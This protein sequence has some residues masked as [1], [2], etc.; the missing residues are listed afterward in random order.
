[1][2]LSEKRRRVVLRLL[3]LVGVITL[4]AALLPASVLAEQSCVSKYTVQSGDTLAR[5]ARSNGYTTQELASA[6]SLSLPYSVQPGDEL[7]RPNSSKATPT[8]EGEKVSKSNKTPKFSAFMTAK[9]LVATAAEFPAKQSY[10]V[11]LRGSSA[12]LGTLRGNKGD[13]LHLTVDLS[14][15]EFSGRSYSVC[16]K[17]MSTNQSYCVP[18]SVV[19][20]K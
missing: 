18:V 6:N 17:N 2:V 4:A 11:K 3:A 5:I 10:Q 20:T 13:T 9:N 8:A 19:S 1:M 14:K 16:F 12:K 7:C 15:I